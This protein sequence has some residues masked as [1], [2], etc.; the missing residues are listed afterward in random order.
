MSHSSHLV[1]TDLPLRSNVPSEPQSFIGDSCALL[2]WD[3]C[4]LSVALEALAVKG[5]LDGPAGN[6][7]KEGILRSKEAWKQNNSI[8][9]VPV[10]ERGP[11]AL[12]RVFSD[13][14]I[15]DRIF[16]SEFILEWVSF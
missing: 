8:E 7:V 9:I 14:V 13:H 16:Q 4:Q 2:R 5:R 11:F 12:D 6:G 1:G 10:N 3:S 15:L